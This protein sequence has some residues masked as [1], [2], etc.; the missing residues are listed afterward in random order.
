VFVQPTLGA[1]FRVFGDS[2]L[3]SRRVRNE[4][5]AVMYRVATCRTPI[6]G[7]HL[8]ACESC[9][10]PVTAWNSCRDRHC[11]QC[12]GRE[13]AD[14]VDAM[15]GRLLPTH[16]FHLVFAVPHELN[17]LILYNKKT[18]YD[19]HFRAV[20]ETIKDLLADPKR[21]G[22]KPA[23]T[24][25]LHTW[26]QELSFHT[27]VHS[28]VSGG[29]LSLDGRSWVASDPRFLISNRVLSPVFRGKYI[30]LLVRAYADDQLT[31]DDDLAHLADPNEFERFKRSLYRNDWYVHAEKPLRGPLAVCKYF[32]GYTHRVG[33]SNKRIIAVRDGRV[34]FLARK[35]AKDG[36]YA[37]TQTKSLE[38]HEFM[39]RFL[40]HALPYG[41]TR[42]RHYG[43]SAPG[44]VNT[45]LALA[46]TL[47]ID[48]G[49]ET[50]PDREDDPATTPPPDP[51]VCPQCGGRMIVLK[52]F[53]PERRNP[54]DTS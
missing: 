25:V 51:S 5:R 11:P 53:D 33:I 9:G 32:A 45:Q 23:F 30:E 41:Y 52:T 21:L 22:A 54:F 47:I 49:A 28:I 1:I 43:L 37:G 46:R 44:N 38:A 36:T 14:W 10:R 6:L 4:Q 13:A 3:T 42:I 15:R 24:S 16:Y 7:G 26:N 12:Q 8:Y 27:H 50:K 34:Y 31:L 39:R 29:G 19:I 18:C 2:Y 35:N 20:A 17:L 40:M 48:A